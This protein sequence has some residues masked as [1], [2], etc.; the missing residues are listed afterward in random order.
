MVFSKKLA[1]ALAVATVLALT[2]VAGANPTGPGGD[3]PATPAPTL[4]MKCSSYWQTA[5]FASDQY[6]F[7]THGGPPLSADDYNDL[8]QMY[9]TAV[10]EYE[11]LGCRALM[12]SPPPWGGRAL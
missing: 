1:G 6:W 12:G 7:S 2:P 3:T 9:L 5:K 11:R 4:S 8:R 10:D